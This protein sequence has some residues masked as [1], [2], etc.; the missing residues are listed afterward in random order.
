ML[1]QILL[2]CRIH[3][4]T[5]TALAHVVRGDL[6]G[7]AEQIYKTVKDYYERNLP[8]TL[9]GP[10]HHGV[11]FKILRQLFLIPSNAMYQR[12]PRPPTAR[13]SNR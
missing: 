9:L 13:P 6:S 5:G 3:R 7:S 2:L 12:M 4:S 8:L 1:A 10:T 11:G